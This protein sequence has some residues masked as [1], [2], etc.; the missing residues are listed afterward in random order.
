MDKMNYS[1]GLIRFTTENSLKGLKSRIWRPRLI[2][3]ILGV[4]VMSTAFIYTMATRIP[5]ELNIERD[6]TTLYRFTASGQ[7]ENAYTLKINNMDTR[8]H[9]YRVRVDG[10]YP[11][12]IKA[13]DEIVVAEGE[14][15]RILVKL[16]LSPESLKTPNADV[17]FV[18][19]SLDDPEVTDSQ[20]SRFIGPR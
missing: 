10:D 17:E 11:F 2:G 4:L 15:R 19:E 16:R 12:D 13:D 18:V 3:Y 9:R 1:R 20:E 7:L 14:V 5:L 6:R 8:D